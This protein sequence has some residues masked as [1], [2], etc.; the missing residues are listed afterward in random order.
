MI[1]FYW[2]LFVL[3]YCVWGGGEGGAKN[4]NSDNH[5]E[6]SLERATEEHTA[7]ISLL[8]LITQQNVQKEKGLD[9]TF[10]L[11]QLSK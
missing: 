5:K 9:I 8:S 6:K 11:K 2:C 1:A 4:P 7:A 10:F 3:L